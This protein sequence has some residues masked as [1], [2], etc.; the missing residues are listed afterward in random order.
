MGCFWGFYYHML[1]RSVF[2]VFLTDA[3]SEN[4]VIC[5]VDD[6][7]T[8]P[9]WL[10]LDCLQYILVHIGVF[11]ACISLFG[12][13]EAQWSSQNLPTSAFLSDMQHWQIFFSSKWFLAMR[14]DSDSLEDSLMKSHFVNLLMSTSLPHRIF[15]MILCKLL[16]FHNIHEVDLN[17][18][19][20]VWKM[21]TF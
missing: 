3:W 15:G 8:L 9:F 11:T 6:S 1:G 18:T 10:M 5:D 20:F 17:V 13:P 4:I 7:K 14:T 16:R 21:K 19:A 2:F 12:N